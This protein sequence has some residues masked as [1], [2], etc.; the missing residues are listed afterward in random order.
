MDLQRR[1]PLRPG[2]LELVGQVQLVGQLPEQGGPPAVGSVV[3]AQRQP[4]LIRRFA[5]RAETGR[6]GGGGR[7]VAQHHRPVA[8]PRGVVRQPPVV[9]R[10]A[11]RQQRQRPGMDAGPQGR[12]QRLVDR[13]PGQLVPEAHG[14]AVGD[15][16]AAVQA[17]VDR[18]ERLAG[19]LDQELHLDAPAEHGSRGKDFPSRSRQPGHAGKHRIPHGGRDSLGACRDDLGDVERIPAGPLVHLAGVQGGARMIEQLPDAGDGKRGNLHPDHAR[20]RGEISQHDGER[21]IAP[22]LFRAEG[23]QDHEPG[24]I[25]PA[26]HEAQRLQGRLVGPVDVLE[27]EQRRR[28][29]QH[30]AHVP[31]QP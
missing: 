16:H 12:G 15:Q 7:R 26:A 9:T 30:V 24:A 13:Q 29:R 1:K 18:C 4:E 5:V 17:L 25:Q 2:V 3:V 14:V 28:R 22:H 23:R 21:V 6:P 31:E 19:R 8:A 27:H 10:P 11:R 20:Q